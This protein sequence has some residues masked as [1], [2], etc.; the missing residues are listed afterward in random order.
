M[1]VVALLYIVRCTNI[2]LFDL[3]SFR[4]SVPSG[5]K[6]S[7]PAIL[8]DCRMVLIFSFS[9]LCVI[10]SSFLGGIANTSP[11]W[12]RDIR[13]ANQNLATALSIHRGLRK[14]RKGECRQVDKFDKTPRCLTPKKKPITYRN[15]LLRSI[16]ILPLLNRR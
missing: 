14:K 16:H 5:C 13:L 4:G 6:Q 15:G 1:C 3:I 12:A 10:W 7:S 9:F 11:A 2:C 8:P